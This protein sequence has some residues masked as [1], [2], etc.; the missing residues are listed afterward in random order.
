VVRVMVEL[1]DA[2]SAI[3]ARFT[4]LEVIARIDTNSKSTAQP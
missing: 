2:S 4:N 1:D 3:A